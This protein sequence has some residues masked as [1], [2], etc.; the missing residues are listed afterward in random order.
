[1]P[2]SLADYVSAQ[3]ASQASLHNDSEEEGCGGGSSSAHHGNGTHLRLSR[4]EQEQA[5][6]GL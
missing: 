5:K 3:H 4:A 2:R 1:M 6:R